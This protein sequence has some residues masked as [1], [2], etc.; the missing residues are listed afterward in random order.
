MAKLK[1]AHKHRWQVGFSSGGGNNFR[2]LACDDV[3]TIGEVERA[4]NAVVSFP[5]QDAV[6]VLWDLEHAAGLALGPEYDALEDYISEL[7]P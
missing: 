6:Q 3:I 7:E 1:I 5:L 2:C 4:M